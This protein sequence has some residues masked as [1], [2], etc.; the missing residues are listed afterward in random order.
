MWWDI[1]KSS[2]DEAYSKF[3]EEFGPGTNPIDWEVVGTSFM[4]DGWLIGLDNLGNVLLGSDDKYK[5]HRDFVLGMF[6]YDENS[7]R[8]VSFLRL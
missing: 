1:L 2:R 8:I 5:T 7:S 4:G 3:L 6:E